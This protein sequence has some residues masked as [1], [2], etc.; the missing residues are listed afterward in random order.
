MPSIDNLNFEVILNDKKFNES[1]A[2]DIKAAN[3]L[4]IAL[5][6]LLDLKKQLG[7]ISQDNVVNNRKMQQI[8]VDNARA[9]EKITRET[10]KTAAAQQALNEKLAREGRSQ[11]AIQQE[12]LTREVLKTVAAQRRL[13]AATKD[14]SKLLGELTTIAAGYLSIRGA[15]Q[16]LS[17]LVRVTGEFEMQKTTLS[18]MLGDMNQAESILTD[19]KGLAVES[20][21][22]YKEL[23]TYA[24]QLSAFSVPAD[25]IFDTTKMLA[26]ISAGL[27]VGMDR[28]ILA[29]GQVRS[30]A[31]LRGQ[32]V[33]QFT[34][35]G[36][37]ILD[38]LARQFTEIEGRAVSA[39]EVFDKISKRLVPFEMV[40]K[41][42]KE[43]TSEGGKFFEMQAIQA[44]TLEG[45]ISNLKDAYDIMMSEIGEANSSTLKGGVDM[46][47]KLMENWKAIGDII[48]SLISGFGMYKATLGAVWAYEKVMA[49]KGMLERYKILAARMLSVTGNARNLSVALRVLGISGKAAVGGVVGIVAALG[50]AI[51]QA[52]RRAGELN[53]ELKSIMS[54]EAGRSDKLVS[55]LDALVN[56]LSS[57]KQGSQNYRDA[58]SELNRK[59]G[60]YLPNLLTEKNTLGEIKTAADKAAE[61]IRNKA[62]ADA[63][64]KGMSKI[65]E[66]YGGKANDEI[67]HLREALK[68]RAIYDSNLNQKSINVLIEKF[69]SAIKDDN[70]KGKRNLDVFNEIYE[71][72]FGQKNKQIYDSSYFDNIAGA[73]T[74]LNENAE[75]LRD[76]LNIRFSDSTY[77]TE[78]ERIKVEEVTFWYEKEEEAIKRLQLEQ[79]EFNE[80]IEELKIE[81]LR[82]L[83]QIYTELHRP[84][85]AQNYQKQLDALTKMQD[86]WKGLVNEYLTAQGLGKQKSY[87]LWTD[88]FTQSA[89]YIDTISKRYKELVGNIK[90][91]S[92]FDPAG[93]ET[94]KKEK[95]AI[96]GIARILNY[97]LSAIDKAAAKANKKTIDRSVDARIRAL[98]RNA[99]LIKEAAD[100]YHDLMKDGFF[101]DDMAREF[102]GRVY[103]DTAAF[104]KGVETWS[105]ALEDMLKKSEGLR[106]EAY[107]DTGGVWTIGYGHTEGVKEGDVITVEQAQEMLVQD[108]AVRAKQLNEA[109]REAGLELTQNQYDALL[110]FTYNAGIGSLRKLIK[111][112]SLDEIGNAILTSN[113]KDSKG[114]TQEGLIK[115]RAEEFLLFT[116][117]FA[118]AVDEDGKLMVNFDEQIEPLLKS[119]RS[120]GA[121]GVKAAEQIEESWG[122]MLRKDQVK[123]FTEKVDN[124]YKAFLKYYEKMSAWA[125]KDFNLGGVGVDF[126]IR[127]I[128]SDLN[129][130]MNSIERRADKMRSLLKEAVSVEEDAD[131]LAS[132][133]TKFESEF[134]T[135]I[136]DRFWDE[137][138]KGGT[139]AIE[140]IYS[141]EKKSA[142]ATAN[143]K[144]VSLAEKKVKE[145][146]K[147]LKLTDWSDKSLRQIND[148]KSALYSL[149]HGN[150]LQ[151]TDAD[152]I[153]TLNR[154]GLS[155]DDLEKAIKD[156]LVGEYN[157]TVIEKFKKLQ[158]HVKETQSLL[159]DIGE[160]VSLL[161]DA[162]DADWLSGSGKMLDTLGE[163][164]NILIEC[165]SLWDSIADTEKEATDTAQEVAKEGEN[166][167]K[168]AD[169]I[170][171]I[172]K[173]ILLVIN[174]I[175]EG[176]SGSSEATRQ[177]IE[178]A[179]QYKLAL[180]EIEFGDRVSSFDTVFGTDGFT[181]Y[182]QALAEAY[183]YN[184]KIQ[185][186]STETFS[187]QD[188][189]KAMSGW[190]SFSAGAYKKMKELEKDFDK[191]GSILVDKRNGWQKFWGTGNKNVQ[192]YSM[193]E[194]F[195]E[196]GRLMTDKLKA[197]Y[198]NN[199]KGL[200][201]Y[202][203]GVIEEMI[204]YGERYDEAMREIA[205][206]VSSIFRNLA[207]DIADSMINSFLEMGDAATGLEDIFENL[208]QTITKSLLESFILDKVLKKYEDKAA[209]LLE[210]SEGIT[211]ESFWIEMA[212]MFTEMK[213][214][215]SDAAPSFNQLFEYLQGINLLPESNGGNGGSLGDGIKN[216]TEDT[217]NLLA[218]YLNA[219]RADV[220]FSKTLWLRMDANTQRIADLLSVMNVPNISEYQAQ[221]AANTYDA[222][223]AANSILSELR[224]LFTYEGGG[225]AIRVYS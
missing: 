5:S 90:N 197:F 166:I 48:T 143:D 54:E 206:Y 161:G 119:L 46:L 130:E 37:P 64:E 216:I 191:T 26:D 140:R 194:F 136:W 164:A 213:E 98:K 145:L 114:Q 214:E 218:S 154:L 177:A 58:I 157:D 141:A 88:D 95:E 55:G 129:T 144:L 211:D 97:D 68:Q 208:G 168:S 35:A 7:N 217:A 94:L 150:D 93:A 51:Y 81:K 79:G 43:M 53:R 116:S 38:E 215:L 135:D 128:A 57:A 91:I 195:D 3:D 133:R 189:S 222:A 75:E 30:A 17:S 117:D 107:Q 33:R 39:G 193:S 121:E 112:R 202:N 100:V 118:M 132:V 21:F 87:G 41:S 155:L 109:I 199:Q 173:V 4:N 52:A 167:A 84:E 170:T 176:I 127:K 2:K 47:R 12:K 31:F 122:K 209:S 32:E 60:E 96:E 181:K 163:F 224:D 210:K 185:S 14:H 20:K 78:E 70:N 171:M 113:I 62:K 25:E 28:I 192:S 172:I 158:E 124:L 175:A 72:Y 45:K 111:D 61:A 149:L 82:R 9:Q 105:S 138:V 120:L 104:K 76:N 123:D 19:I 85:I 6:D 69:V 184:E 159:G 92:S 63:Y 201:D 71:S 148:I 86:G 182:K 139:N 212:G 99:D 203:R 65:E 8:T 44:E 151:L 10:Q 50:V 146:T 142:K 106:T 179:R 1:I 188:F 131:A 22:E 221:I 77:D 74:K 101:T 13:N 204:A 147:G 18:A 16:L 108:M 110:D 165:D 66:K 126:D 103:G 205:D 219:I 207:S 190:S 102:L 29:Y 34:E 220:S 200:S 134:G 223:V 23:A 15:G 11:A 27:G 186:L 137:Y 152:T 59:Y 225:K 56:K 40:A 169:W 49:A 198:E 89:E 73:L 178:D 24:K 187:L 180:D 160:T 174:K 156:I 36:I 67:S 153:S 183:S 162:F 115:R 80:K 42:F 125:G 83:V 196:E